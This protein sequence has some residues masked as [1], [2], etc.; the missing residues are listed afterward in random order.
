MPTKEKDNMKF[1]SS[2]A[3]MP[4]IGFGTAAYPYNG[5]TVDEAVT[6]GLE[7]GFRHFDTA[8]IY[9][10]EAATGRALT[11]AICSGE[12]RR[13]ELFVTSKLWGSDHHDPVAALRQSLRNLDLEYLDLYLVHWPA[14]FKEWATYAVPYEEDFDVLDMESTWARLERCVDLGLCKAIGV[15]NFS[16]TKIDR[17]LNHASIPP[18]VN[19]V[20]MHPRWRQKKLREFCEERNIHVS[21]YSPM[22]GPGNSWGT[23]AVVDNPIIMAIAL[24]H[25]ATPAQVALRWGIEKG[26]SVITKTFRRE[27]MKEN[28]GALDIRLDEE[29]LVEIDRLEEWKVMRGEFL[30]N[31]TT[32]PYK[33]IQE[34]WDGEI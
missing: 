13:E 19:Q 12:V 14:R 34:L 16:C 15:S 28:L 3:K 18:A 24:K 4:V 29:D 31:Q 26:A 20:E 5:D 23:T 21:A 9:G 6:M 11:A 2:D 25:N 1:M 10:S 8:K 33:S 27:R 7:V 17:L 22:G 32:S 30:V